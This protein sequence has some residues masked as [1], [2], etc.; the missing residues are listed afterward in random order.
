[1]QEGHAVTEREL[2]MFQKQFEELEDLVIRHQRALDNM[3]GCFK[4]IWAVLVP[5]AAMFF[6][7]VL[8]GK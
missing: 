8:F 2:S 4:A 1:M 5:V 6:G 3:K 7:K